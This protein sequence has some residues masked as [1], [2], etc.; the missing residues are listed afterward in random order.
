[1]NKCIFCGN[2]TDDFKVTQSQSGTKVAR[3]GMALN[4]GKDK[5]GNDKGA[6]FIN[7]V[8]FSSDKGG[9]ADFFEKFGAKGRKF[10]I[11][12]HVQTG[13]YE[14]DGKKVYTTDFVVDKAEFVDSK[15]SAPAEQ[16]QETD[17]FVDVAS[18][19]DESLPFR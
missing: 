1:M 9:M 17:G 10:L 8:A 13:S 3:G 2:L 7:L 4:R 18:F 12:T 16:P 15:P 6:D 14:K 11:E 5:S 19:V